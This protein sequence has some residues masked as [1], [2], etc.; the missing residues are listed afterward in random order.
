MQR[1]DDRSPRALRAGSV[2]EAERIEGAAVFL[3]RDGTL[4]A[5]RGPLLSPAALELL[6]GVPDALRRLAGVG[7]RLIVVTN[8]SAVGRGLLDLA[9]LERIHTALRDALAAEGAAIDGLYFCPDAPGPLGE[10]ESPTGRRKPGTGMLVE[11]A[12]DHALDLGRC[13][14]IGDQARDTRAGQRAGCRASILLR[15][16]QGESFAGCTNDFDLVCDDLPA[17]ADWILAAGR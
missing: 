10:P 3:D 14:M 16:G 13:F 15:T 5:D 17:A 11:A 8:Q 12:R 1:R 2:S 9:G 7:Y 6:P 4:I